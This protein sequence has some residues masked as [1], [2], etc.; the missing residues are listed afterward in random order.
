MSGSGRD[1]LGDVRQWSGGPPGCAEVVGSP[2]EMSR[3]GRVPLGDVREWSGDPFRCAGV[4][5]GCLGV[6]GDPLGCAGVPHRCPGVVRRP[7]WLSRS[8]RDAL[9]DVREW[10]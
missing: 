5:H 4:T 6:V 10:L 8:V 2:S 3:S 9:G 1:A 7:F